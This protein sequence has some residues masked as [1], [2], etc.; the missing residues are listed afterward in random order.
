MQVLALIGGALARLNPTGSLHL[1]FVASA[2]DAPGEGGVVADFADSRDLDLT[3]PPGKLGQNRA[4]ESP[5]HC[6]TL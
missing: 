6:Y 3:F 4:Q 5:E 1:R 2:R